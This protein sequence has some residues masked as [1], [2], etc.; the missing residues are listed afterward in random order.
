MKA[1]S[2]IPC[3]GVTAFN[4]KTHEIFHDD[5]L[6]DTEEEI[7]TLYADWVAEGWVLDIKTF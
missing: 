6:F 3:F 2:C 7:E 1:V 5:G 4:P